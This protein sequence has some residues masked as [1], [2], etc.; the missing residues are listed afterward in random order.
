MQFPESLLT[1]VKNSLDASKS[2]LSVAES[3]TAGCLQWACSSME[4]ATAIFAGGI[5]A[6]TLEEKVRVLHVDKEEA[7]RCNS[8]SQKI[9]NQMAIAAS[10]LFFTE[11]A[12]ATTGYATVVEESKGRLFAFLSISYLKKIVYANK[13]EIPPDTAAKIAQF[14]Y[15]LKALEA[16]HH[17]L[18]RQT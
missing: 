11:W 7:S 2:R 9:T 6:Y 1:E 16:L 15:S 5:T 17:F 12:I 8:V 3:V 4:N 13:I 14:T 18:T 10:E